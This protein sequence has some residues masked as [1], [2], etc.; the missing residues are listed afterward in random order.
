MPLL[1]IVPLPVPPG[2]FVPY[3]VVLPW[4]SPMPANVAL[5]MMTRPLAQVFVPF[6]ETME[7]L[8][9]GVLGRV[10]AMVL[11]KIL[12]VFIVAKAVAFV[13]GGIRGSFG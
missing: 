4:M 10:G 5:F 7:F 1:V 13:I 3:I 8:G 9:I 12:Y 11:T 2:A 6:D